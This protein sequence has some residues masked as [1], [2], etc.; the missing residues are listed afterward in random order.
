MKVIYR[1][2]TDRID[3]T[4]LHLRKEGR[5]PLKLKLERKEGMWRPPKRDNI[6][7]D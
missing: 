5:K 3:N 4:E 6:S 2:Q 1:L 7:D